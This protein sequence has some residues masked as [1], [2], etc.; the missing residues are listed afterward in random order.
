MLVA[1]N[2]WEVAGGPNT[3]TVAVLLVAPGPLCVE[4]MGP[5]VLF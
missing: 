1:P 2:D 5:V 4:E 3:V